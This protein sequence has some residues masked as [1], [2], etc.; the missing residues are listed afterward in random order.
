M[1]SLPQPLS[2]SRPARQSPQPFA[3]VASVAECSSSSEA[4]SGRRPGRSANS[5]AAA[6]E[7]CAAENDVPD[8]WRKSFGPQSE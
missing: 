5:I 1:S 7:T 3:G 2:A 8:A 4:W 6:A